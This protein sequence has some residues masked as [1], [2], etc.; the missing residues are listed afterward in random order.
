M[1][2][3][4]RAQLLLLPRI[5]SGARQPRRFQ[6]MS[7]NSRRGVCAGRTIPSAAGDV[8]PQAQ[9]AK[10]AGNIRALRGISN[11]PDKLDKAYL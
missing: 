3:S 9:G 7:N 8:V 4:R 10:R 2:R 6:R 11:A 5:C 1:H